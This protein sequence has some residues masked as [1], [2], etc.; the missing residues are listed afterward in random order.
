MSV[1]TR[2]PRV[3]GAS[4]V[5][6]T[7][8]DDENTGYF[9]GSVWVNTTTG[10]AYMCASSAPGAALWTPLRPDI[11]SVYDSLGNQSFT[12][13]PVTVNLDSLKKN[14][15][16]LIYTLS[17][18]V[19]AINQPGTYLFLYECTLTIVSGNNRSQAATRLEEN[20]GTG[21][22]PV[23]GSYSRTYN[24]NQAEGATTAASGLAFD[25]PSGTQIRLRAQ[26]IAGNATIGTVDGGS[27][28]TIMRIL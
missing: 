22:T 21:W 5:D 1:T 13:V 8:N 10:I 27:R 26:R 28:L 20:P 7:V 17:N 14:T 18:D 3:N 9:T 25:I 15:N 11:I 19:I 6:P 24:R 23:D 2:T 12:T 4:T 16:A